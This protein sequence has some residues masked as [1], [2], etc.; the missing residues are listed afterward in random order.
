[1]TSKDYSTINFIVC[2]D[3]SASSKAALRFACLKAKN[4]G[5]TVNMLYVVE[6]V[7]FQSISSVA[8]AMLEEQIQEGKKIL[9]H[10]ANEM[11][12]NLAIRPTG[13][14]LPG[15]VGE[16]IIKQTNQM[17]GNPAMLVLGV[18][19]DSHNVGKLVAWVCAQIGNSIK[20]PVMLVPGNLSDDEMLAL[21]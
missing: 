15:K 12:D 2:V 8:E 18:I 9:D 19:Q 13:I 3:G 14:L 17:A 11:E 4:H 6:P 10:L 5:G 21:A 16:E 1:M 7:D 20:L